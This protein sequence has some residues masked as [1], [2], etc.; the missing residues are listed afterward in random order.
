MGLLAGATEEPCSHA[1]DC[2]G[3][4][5]ALGEHEEARGVKKSSQMTR[6]YISS[7]IPVHPTPDSLLADSALRMHG[8]GLLHPFLGG[9]VEE[10]V[11]VPALWIR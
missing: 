5:G 9:A 10:P 8:Q 7:L 1:G 3:T 2:R 11:E 6:L 4:G